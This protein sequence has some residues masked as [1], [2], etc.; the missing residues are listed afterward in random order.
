MGRRPGRTH[1]DAR[2]SPELA[3]FCRLLARPRSIEQEEAMWLKEVTL[4]GGRTD[5]HMR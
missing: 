4:A 2:Q 3:A 5:G 1:L